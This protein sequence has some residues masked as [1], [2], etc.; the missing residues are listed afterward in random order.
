VR[1]G[2]LLFLGNALIFAVCFSYPMAKIA[3]SLRVRYLEAVEEP[4]VDQ[5]NILAALVGREMEDGRFDPSVLGSVF[6]A[7]RARSVAAQIYEVRKDRVDIEIYVTDGSGRVVFDSAHPQNV[8]ADY[9][10]W[11]DVK[12]TLAGEYGAR[13][14]RSVVDDPAS[15]LLHVAAPILAQGRTVGV[16]TVVEPVTS[17]NSFLRAAKPRVFG[18]GAASGAAALLLGLLLSW[19]VSRQIG[20]LTRY[21]HDVRQGKRVELP[22]LAPT[23]LREMGRAFE[24]MRESLEGKKYV[25]QYVQTLTHEIKSPVSAIRG[26]A[27]LLSDELPQARRERLLAN[28]RNESQR[29]SDLVERMLVLSELETRRALDAVAVALAPLL[30]TIVESKEPLVARKSLALALDLDE[31]VTLRGDAFLLH[32]AI[33]NLLEN[34]IDFS[35]AGGRIALRTRREDGHVELSIEDE[36]PGVPG[37]ALERVFEKFFSLERP[38]TGKKSTGL[39]L[40]LVREV[41]TLHGGEV[42]LENLPERGLRAV[43]RL[44]LG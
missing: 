1:L 29:I 19:W 35:P 24:K 22:R 16:L 39:G 33:A 12:R 14:T 44:P 41:A 31:S 18:V 2:T 37:Y 38:D 21:A 26:A 40:N 5:A 27:E 15:T 3:S 42:R 43:L 23:E 7:V 17:I 10:Q 34:A 30:R 13:A 4:L 9:S 28:I 20:R 32:Q 6:D 11:V 25:E 8:G 36:G